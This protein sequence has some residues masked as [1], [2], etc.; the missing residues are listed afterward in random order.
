MRGFRGE[1][2]ERGKVADALVAARSQGIQMR[3]NAE[4]ALAG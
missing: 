4:A 1:A 3:R 2:G